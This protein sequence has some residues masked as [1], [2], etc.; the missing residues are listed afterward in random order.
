MVECKAY[1]MYLERAECLE[2]SG[3]RNIIL[4]HRIGCPTACHR[5]TA[6]KAFMSRG[7]YASERIVFC[8]DDTKRLFARN[9]LRILL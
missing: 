5:Y 6:V 2:D 1:S 7:H 8:I 3:Y 4:F 9:W